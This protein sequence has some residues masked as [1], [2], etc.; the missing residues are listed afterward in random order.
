MTRSQRLTRRY[1]PGMPSVWQI[2]GL[3]KVSGLAKTPEGAEPADAQPMLLSLQIFPF[4]GRHLRLH[5]TVLRLIGVGAS[6]W[7]RQ[8]RSI[9][10]PLH[11]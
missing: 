7:L 1:F 8:K 9:G 4:E 10:P 5:Q 6:V 11:I 3:G 2:R